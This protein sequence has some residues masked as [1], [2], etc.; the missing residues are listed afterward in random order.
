MIHQDLDT[1]GKPTGKVWIFIPAFYL[2]S[3]EVGDGNGK[4]R[5]TTFVYEIRCAP[6]KH[7][8]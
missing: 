8:C 6:T 2:H 5:V 4:D 3:R 7:T 1:E